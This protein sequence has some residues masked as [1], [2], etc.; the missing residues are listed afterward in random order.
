MRFSLFLLG[1]LSFPLLAVG[2]VDLSNDREGESF[3]SSSA[4]KR[5]VKKAIRSIEA[6]LIE[7]AY[8]E[9]IKSSEA[10]KLC[11]FDLNA[12]LL[13]RLKNINPKFSELN[14]AII[15]LRSRNHFDDIVTKML[16]LANKTV[17]TSIL[18]PKK[19]EDLFYPDNKIVVESLK[20]MEG[21]DKKIK[22]SCF[23]E[24]YRS[25]Y[26]DILRYDKHL[27]GHHIE[28]IFVNAF[29]KKVISYDT[30]LALERGRMNELQQGT[31]TLKSYL[32]KIQS[33]RNQFPL[34]DP[35]EKSNFVTVKIDKINVSRRQRLLEGYTDL[36]IMLMANVIK[37][38]RTRIES[39]KAEILIYDRNQGIE[40][41]ALE[42]MERFRLSIK[43]LRR[44]MSLLSLNT[45]FAGRAP[46][47]MDLM[48]AAF[49]TGIIPASELEEIAGLE[50]I[51][52]PKRAFWD[53]AQMW[54]RTF[55]SVVTIAIPPP[56]GFIPAL[57]IV[58]IE[59][60]AVKNKEN[61]D[62]PTV[63]F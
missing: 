7:D 43:L 13:S 36:Q 3:Y 12:S 46:D 49:E 16:L 27:K 60:T 4:D 34:R 32:K 18:L 39:P 11:S 5:A 20:V 40:T 1:L 26:G 25:V 53:K 22:T 58:V 24:V 6:T 35:E 50:E 54:V 31:T 42:P 33:L 44:E 62:D 52:N 29:E 41:I 2:Q 10:S 19:Q 51:W 28:A 61:K 9:T 47:Y 37:K 15:Y 14:G 21:L 48:T 63:L 45:Y 30:Y 38:L 56:Y 17:N 8:L 23:D 55:S 57:A 59:M